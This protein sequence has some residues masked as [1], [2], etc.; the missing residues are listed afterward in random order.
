MT[1]SSDRLFLE[2]LDDLKRIR[3]ELREEVGRLDGEIA[4]VDTQSRSRDSGLERAIIAL[5]EEV[6]ELQRNFE[7]LLIQ[8]DRSFQTLKGSV[9]GMAASTASA[10]AT[11]DRTTAEGSASV[12]LGV[13]RSEATTREGLSRVSAGVAMVDVLQAISEAQQLSIMVDDVTGDINV[14][15]VGA[16]LAVAEKQRAYDQAAMDVYDGLEGHLGRIGE[17]IV[18]LQGRMTDLLEGLGVAESA[19]SLLEAELTGVQLA[20]TQHRARAV[21]DAIRGIDDT[22]LKRAIE[23]RDELESFVA[24]ESQAVLTTGAQEFSGTGLSL[25]FVFVAATGSATSRD[26]AMTVYG[27]AAKLTPLGGELPSSVLPPELR[28]PIGALAGRLRA[29]ATRTM[30]ADEFGT[31]KRG[32]TE[33]RK[34]DAITERDLRLLSDHLDTHP[35][36]VLDT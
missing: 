31:L 3:Q 26:D 28:N 23:W 21:A 7:Q 13:Q 9:E 8:I 27:L 5:Q 15:K 4:S 32:L 35:I 10:L 2:L 18:A 12:L 1:D 6:K 24:D 22:E 14:R 34:R 17:H 20:V 29:G 11:L 25:P 33:L 16:N 30:S 36:G 19:E